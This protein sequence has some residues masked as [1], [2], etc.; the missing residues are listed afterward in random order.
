MS[1]SIFNGTA[2]KILK[3]ILKF[4]DG[5]TLSSTVAGYLSTISSDIQTQVTG[6]TDKSTLTTKGDIYAATAASTPA[7]LGVGA[8]GTVLTADSTQATGVK[9]ETPA[10]G[11]PILA[12]RSVTTT[13]TCTNADDL[14]VL[15]GASFTQTLFT[16]AGNTGKVITIQHAGAD[17]LSQ[18]YTLNTTSAQT[19]GG[20]ASGA[21]ALYT[22][23]ETLKIISDGS[24]WLIL[25][26]KADT[27]WT[28]YTPTIGGFGTVSSLDAKWK[29]DGNK[30]SI[31]CFFVA[32]TV[33]ASPATISLPGS[34]SI[35]T[36]SVIGNQIDQ[37]GTIM[38]STV[39]IATL[40]VNSRGPW[41]AY[42]N[43]DDGTKIYFTDTNDSDDVFFLPKN[44]NGIGQNGC[45]ILIRIEDAPITGWKP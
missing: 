3:N 17:D 6:K 43:D 31:K 5:T 20:H 32:G 22:K 7:R 33:A 15:S 35:N 9:W 14:L 24:N 19:I 36:S 23:G 12:V 16:A 29:R 45:K 26:H 37:F 4:K 41:P 10:A 30:I 11:S 38:M 8:D 27:E 42:Y 13:D 28:V 34:S 21:Y 40:P 44:G 25:D 2:V 39:T 1:A 18:V